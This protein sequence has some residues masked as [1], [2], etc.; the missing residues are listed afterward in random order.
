[1]VVAVGFI[2]N[3]GN[4]A[5]LAA[6][7]AN[8]NIVIPNTANIFLTAGVPIPNLDGMGVI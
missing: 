8:Y 6:A 7:T 5:S 3:S 1:L 2:Y 4:T